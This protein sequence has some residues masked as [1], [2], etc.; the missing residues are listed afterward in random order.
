MTLKLCPLILLNKEHFYWKI[1]QKYAL[2]AIL[3]PPFN[4]DK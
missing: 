3:R 1:M 2:E 4:F